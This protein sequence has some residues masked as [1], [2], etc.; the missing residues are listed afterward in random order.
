MLRDNIFEGFEED[1]RKS[2]SKHG[3]ICRNEKSDQYLCFYKKDTNNYDYSFVNESEI[4]ELVGLKSWVDETKRNEFLQY[5]G[6]SLENY[7]KLPFSHKA[8][9]LMKFF[10]NEDIMGKSSNSLTYNEV[11]SMIENE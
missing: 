10:G 5:C 2:L 3:F 7:Y 8:Y 1:F 9:S 4:D 6:Q 11:I